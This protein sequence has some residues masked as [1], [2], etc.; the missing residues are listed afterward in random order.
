MYKGKVTDDPTA[1]CA[2]EA[3]MRSNVIKL[4]N[5]KDETLTWLKSLPEQYESGLITWNEMVLKA[6]EISSIAVKRL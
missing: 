3:A 4:P 1:S 5:H 2:I 6:I